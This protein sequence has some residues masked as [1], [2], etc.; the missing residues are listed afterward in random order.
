MEEYISAYSRLNNAQKRAVDT[1]DGSLL[2]IAGPGTGKTQLLAVRAGRILKETDVSPENILCISFTD[3]AAREMR[4]RLHRLLGPA[5]SRIEVHT[6]HSFG[7]YVISRY[8]ELFTNNKN[9]LTQLD[10]IAQYELLETLLERLPLRHP[11]GVQ[12]ESG[13][14]ISLSLVRN[15]IKAIK[16]AALTT[17]DL[18]VLLKANQEIITQIQ[19]ILQSAFDTPRLSIKQ[20]DI[21]KSAAERLMS[22]SDASP[23]F[24]YPNLSQVIANSLLQATET[25]IEDNKTGALGSW[26]DEYLPRVDGMR[27]LRAGTKADEFNSLIKLYETYQAHLNTHSLYDYDDMILWTLDAL[28]TNE[29]LRLTL[30]ER[31]LYIMVDEY[32]D[33][34]GAQNKLVDALSGID[35]GAISP[36][37]LVVGDDDQAIMRFQG[38][39]I[40]N[41]LMFAEKY[42]PL[43]VS[44]TDNYRSQQRILDAARKVI[45]RTDDRLELSLGPK[46]A[47][48]ILDSKSEV[49]DSTLER[50]EFNTQAEEFAW[51]ANEIDNLLATDVSANTVCII[52][53]RH[54][55]LVKLVPFLQSKAIPVSYER[56]ENILEK[57]LIQQ[58]LRVSEFLVAYSENQL[59]IANGL[60]PEILSYAFWEISNE[61]RLFIAMQ[62]AKNRTTWLEEGLKSTNPKIKNIIDLL[63]ITADQAQSLP[64]D[65]ALDMIIGSREVRGSVLGLSPFKAFYFNEVFEET[66]SGEFMILLSHLI[67]LRT[68]LRDHFRAEKPKL[69]NF[70]TLLRLYERANINILDENPLTVNQNAIQ[71]MTAHKSKG[72]EFEHVFIINLTDEA[73]GMKA[74]RGKRRLYLPEN[75]PIYPAG[76]TEADKLRLLYVALT[77]AKFDLRL[78]SHTQ[79]DNARATSTLSLIDFDGD[80]WW[81]PK[82]MEIVPFEQRESIVTASWQE[83]YDVPQKKLSELLEHTLLTYQLSPT[84]LKNFLD[85]RYGGPASFKRIHL[86]RFP[87]AQTFQSCFGSAIHLALEYAQNHM[88]REGALP[89]IKMVIG[90]AFKALDGMQLADDELQLAKAHASKILPP[91]YEQ[92]KQDWGQD[93]ITEHTF[94]VTFNGIRARGKLDRL[95]IN[96]A[97]GVRIIDYK[98]GK[99]PEPGWQ[100]KGLSE[101]KRVSLHFNRQ[102]L[103]FYELLS[104]YAPI[105][106]QLRKVEYAELRYVEPKISGELVTLQITEFEQSE[107]SQLEQLI[108]AVWKHIMQLDFPDTTM[109][110]NTLK[111]I[112]TFQEDLISG[113]I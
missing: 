61:D 58:L 45:T 97:G 102:Q 90:Y 39:E 65:Y 27:K 60:L 88:K 3:S 17:D 33:T 46:I 91:F 40:S 66:V 24:G 82:I 31:Y 71:L 79:N 20:V 21:F 96:K 103:L 112:L 108:S 29:D 47:N 75:L 51:I 36:N 62:A 52:A 74:E 53:P 9:E 10:D 85:L 63:V 100:T 94:A 98:T 37:V 22:M 72:Q 42:S 84:H 106:G 15:A 59:H 26:R 44:L 19:P 104:S 49:V 16:Q 92:E 69:S 6:F 87:E 56:R 73:W 93:D 110:P 68:K 67:T 78:T 54:Q 95:A 13:Q 77:R 81:S 107:R 111:G 101:S 35:K 70:V 12:D 48:K 23:I 7:A 11:L 89:T 86:L 41:I 8:P 105:N 32:Q 34:N 76:N 25:A 99:P 18:R 80:G 30:A 55:I 1:I 43:V 5:G 28:H 57:P 113:T 14:F 83:T 50:C 2:V 4:A 38:A 109:Y 64:L